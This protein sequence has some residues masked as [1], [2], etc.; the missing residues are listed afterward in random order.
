[1]FIRYTSLSMWS[2]IGMRVSG[3]GNHHVASYYLDQEDRMPK[4]TL[5]YFLLCRGKMVLEKATEAQV[6][7]KISALIGTKVQDEDDING[8][9]F[10]LI[11][12]REIPMKIDTGIR[13]AL[14]K[15]THKKEPNGTK[16]SRKTLPATLTE[17]STPTAS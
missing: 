16:K 2:Y 8:A 12:G 17:G 1:M 14:T 7:E 9:D 4:D 3:L 5:L 13:V 10:R 15:R 11:T 6:H